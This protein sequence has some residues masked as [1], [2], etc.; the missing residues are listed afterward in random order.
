MKVKSESEVAQPCPTLRD[1]M[2]CCAP[3]SSVNGIFQARVLEWGAIAFSGVLHHWTSSI[4]SWGDALLPLV[5]CKSHELPFVI[6]FLW[7]ESVQSLSHVLLFA[8]PWTAARQASLSITDFQS[9]LKLM[10]ITLVMPFNHLI[11]CRPFLLPPSIFPNIRVFSNESALR[12]R[13]PKYWNFSFNISP[14]IEYLGLIS[15]RMD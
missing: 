13:W 12:I 5:G 11:H 7:Y 4:L 9:L 8:T 15:F 1:P 2:D 10:S 3:G 14:S 6:P